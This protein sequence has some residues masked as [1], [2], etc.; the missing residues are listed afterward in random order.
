MIIGI[1]ARPLIQKKT[2]I[3]Y[4]LQYLL[5]NILENDKENEYILFSDREIFFNN[6]KYN[7]VKFVVDEKS[8]LKKTFWYLLSYVIASQHILVTSR[9]LLHN[10]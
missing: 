6:E 4:Y 2:G 10:S 7:N 8:K 9:N 3:G 1:D 5:E